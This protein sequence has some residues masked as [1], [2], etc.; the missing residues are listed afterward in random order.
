MYKIVPVERQDRSKETIIKNRCKPS[1]NGLQRLFLA[2]PAGFEPVACRL[3]G[4]RSIQ[5]SYGGLYRKYSILQGSRIRTVRLLGGGRSILLS[6]QGMENG[7]PVRR[8][9]FSGGQPLFY[10]IPAALS[11]AHKKIVEKSS[12]SAILLLRSVLS[13]VIMCICV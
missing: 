9:N 8:G 2:P 10:P 6:Y 5:L 11:T 1:K 12:L 7:F 4:D 3:G 13:H